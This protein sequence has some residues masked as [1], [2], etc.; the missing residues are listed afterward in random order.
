[1]GGLDQ[2]MTVGISEA[3]AVANLWGNVQ[4]VSLQRFSSLF[5]SKENSLYTWLMK[6]GRVTSVMK[7][8]EGLFDCCLFVNRKCL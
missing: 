7:C 1:M 4:F 3:S 5:L 8:D 2:L 6:T